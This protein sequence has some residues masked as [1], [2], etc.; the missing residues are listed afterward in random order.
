MQHARAAVETELHREYGITVE[1][2]DPEG[3]SA[4]LREGEARA[5]ARDRLVCETHGVRVRVDDEL[6]YVVPLRCSPADERAAEVFALDCT[7]RRLLSGER[8]E[9]SGRGLCNQDVFTRLWELRLFKPLY[10]LREP[11]DFAA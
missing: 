1:S 8:D 7:I 2:S 6:Q 10:D 4:C 11:V 3:F 9:S 5:F